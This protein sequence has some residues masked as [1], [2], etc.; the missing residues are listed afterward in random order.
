M[1]TGEL[2]LDLIRAD[3]EDEVVSLLE[4]AGHWDNPANWRYLGDTENNFSSIGNQQSNPVPAL[5]EKLING[6]D[7]RLLNGCLER[8]IS[9]ESR[10]APKNIREAVGTFFED[11]ES[12][13]P[14]D[15]GLISLWTNKQATSEGEL[16][17]LSA[18]G[19]APRNGSGLPC[20]TI[21]DA[22]EG[23]TPDNF[24]STFLSLHRS[25]KLRVPFVQGKFNMGATGA[26]QFCSPK[27]RL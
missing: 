21:A 16:L 6:V 10:D 26:L 22:G 2:C 23:Q 12:E 14:P 8:G 17:T 20:F 27:Y 24:P 1:S 13:L 11:H 18:T 9:P 3:T 5:I 7:A 15:A 19:H 4:E 25:N